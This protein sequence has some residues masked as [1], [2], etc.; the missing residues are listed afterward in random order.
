MAKGSK[1]TPIFS[2]YTPQS[3]NEE[4]DDNDASL[5]EMSKMYYSLCGNN[6]TRAKN[7]EL[8]DIINELN[9]V[10][11]EVE[12][13]VNES[14]LGFDLLEKEL[15][16][17]KHTNANANNSIYFEASILIR[18]PSLKS[19]HVSHPYLLVASLMFPL[20]TASSFGGGGEISIDVSFQLLGVLTILLWCYD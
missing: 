8:I 7:D 20:S 14:N 10:N 3:E 18:M 5:L 9:E 17:E 16:D 4:E 2:R 15:H 19:T 11:E 6:I 1:V 12:S 13:L